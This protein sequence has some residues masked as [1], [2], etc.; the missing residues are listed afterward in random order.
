MSGSVAEPHNRPRVFLPTQSPYSRNQNFAEIMGN[1]LF[2]IDL[3]MQR[4][5]RPIPCCQDVSD[6]L[7]LG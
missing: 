5:D 1:L 7:L 4:A 6:A 3:L 2:A